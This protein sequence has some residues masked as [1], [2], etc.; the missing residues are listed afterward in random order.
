VRLPASARAPVNPPSTLPEEHALLMREVTVRAQRVLG[1]A[2]EGQWPRLELQEL[3]NYLRLEV[4]RQIV[5]TEWLLFRAARHAPDDLAE[6]RRDHLA[7]RGTIDVLAQAAATAGTVDGMSPPQLAVTTRDLLAQLTRHLA[8][9]EDLLATT[10]A[11]APGIASLGSKPHE[12][13]ELIEGPTIDLNLLSGEQAEEA[14]RG[15]LLRLRPGE[16]VEVRSSNDPSPLWHSLLRADPGGY[17]ICYLEQSPLQWRVEIT[18]HPGGWS[19]HPF[20]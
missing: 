18:R 14:V 4:L 5:D 6:L 13:Y 11:A 15:R 1:V 8:A 17:G 7:L 16:Q 20:A 10:G 2:D 12:W 9:E 19:P 3:L